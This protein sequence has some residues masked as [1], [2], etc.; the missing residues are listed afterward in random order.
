MARDINEAKSNMSFEEIYSHVTSGIEYKGFQKRVWQ[1]V[2]ND[3]AIAESILGDPLNVQ[4]GIEENLSSGDTLLR[5]FLQNI[6]NTDNL[7]ERKMHAAGLINLP[8]IS[9]TKRTRIEKLIRSIVIKSG[10]TASREISEILNRS[11]KLNREVKA[12]GNILPMQQ[13]NSLYY[14]NRTIMLKNSNEAKKA[15]RIY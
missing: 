5:F 13:I 15:E 3:M 11:A 9:A 14:L 2:L 10:N 12:L 6:V 8:G 1:K 7:D 4:A